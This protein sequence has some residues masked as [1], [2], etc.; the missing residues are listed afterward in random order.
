MPLVA[1]ALILPVAPVFPSANHLVGGAPTYYV[2]PMGNDS[3]DGS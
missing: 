1:L 3:N 2:S